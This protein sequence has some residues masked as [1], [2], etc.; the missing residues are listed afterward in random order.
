MNV[1]D[2]SPRAALSIK[3]AFRGKTLRE[4]ELRLS[5]CLSHKAHSGERQ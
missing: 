5:L 4:F 2:L 3:P 1:N